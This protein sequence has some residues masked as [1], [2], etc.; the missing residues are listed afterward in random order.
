VP[1]DEEFA[2]FEEEAHVAFAYAAGVLI[3]G[4]EFES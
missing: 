4:H 1:G 3:M 2:L